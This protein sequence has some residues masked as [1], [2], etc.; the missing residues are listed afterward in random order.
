MTMRIWLG[1]VV[2]ASAACS[3]M[4]AEASTQAAGS[5][6]HAKLQ[7]VPFD[8]VT[9]ED[10]FWRPR[11]ETNRKVTL[12]HDIKWCEETG[13]ID[14][15]AKAGKLM[16]GEF[17]GTYFD[18]S[19]VYKVLEGAA[20][21][22][23][24]HP[25][26]AIE[27]KVDEI[28]DKIAAAQQPDGYLMSYYILT[29][30]DKRWTNLPKMHELYCAGHLFEAAVAYH[31]ATGKDKLLKVACKLAD[32]IDSVFGPG[33][34]LGYPGHQEIELALVKLWRQTGERRYLDLAEFFIATRGQK[35]NPA[36]FWCQAHLPICEQSE[37]VGHAVRA[38]YFYSGVADLAAVSGSKCYLDAME[39]LWR[40]VAGRKMYVTG[41]IG[42]TRHHEAFGGEYELPNDTAYAETCAAIGMAFWNHRML[43]LHGE[44]RFADVLERVVYNGALSGVSLDGEK[45]FYVNPLASRGKHHRKP[46][47]Q[48]ACCPTNV[49]RFLPS[50]AGYV[51][52][53]GDDSAY[54][55]LY[56]ASTGKM[57]V[58][59]KPIALIQ[60]TKYPWG[61]TVRIAVQ[62]PEPTTFALNLR[63]P[64]WARSYT[65]KVK[66]QAVET[67]PRSG[68]A[69]VRREW[70]SGDEVE[71]DL[72]M[73]VERVAAHPNVAADV[74]RVALQRG[75]IV[76]CLEG[77]DH[78]GQVRNIALSR[79]SKLV[80]RFDPE[81]LGGVTVIEGEALAVS[82]IDVPIA[83]YPSACETKPVKIKAV[84]YYAWDNREGGE[85]VVWIPENP[86]LADASLVPTATADA[87]V[88]ASAE[89]NRVVKEAVNDN[90][91]PVGA[92]DGSLPRFVWQDK[93]GSREW[94]GYTFN[95]PQ[96][97]SRVDVY[98][99]DN[100][101]GV[102]VP[103][104]WRVLW[105][106]QHEWVPVE[107]L[108][109]Y[110]TVK[111]AWNQVEF[112]P[113]PVMELRLEVELQEKVS[114]GI[115]EWRVK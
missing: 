1:L 44:G 89:G 6:T 26:E 109:L 65:L 70:Q 102:Q 81:L 104:S 39:R 69:Q 27:A 103:K 115:V 7:A 41:G 111:N 67:K 53:V 66:G 12:P 32:H 16:E 38:M 97:V 86:A 13:R 28:I 101:G 5:G 96:M 47:Y 56:I 85:M 90:L 83:L 93:A 14:N 55:N 57:T 80:G 107:P 46:W 21:T 31:R 34:Q 112:K 100:G 106:K 58:A 77:V 36:E 71:L 114:A 22:L 24:Q 9:I 113:V 68:Y 84:P 61:G 88:S 33:K 110:T 2:V 35:R 8:Q 25:D 74:G 78:G 59:G 94:I 108:G 19:D 76:Y 50:I 3:A 87:T 43:M 29:G 82:P 30:L 37:I 105:K 18:D 42:A 75:P 73:E 20:Y 95:R 99:V 92:D 64:E 60:D 54:V 23:K 63:I 49:V 4:G 11:I 51:Y 48:T 52:A 17:Q 40:N 91:A 62:V 45:F 79:E 98:W 10:E 72:P 15:F